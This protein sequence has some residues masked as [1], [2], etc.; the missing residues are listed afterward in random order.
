MTRIG[1][2]VSG[3]ATAEN[4]TE[5]WVIVIGL[6]VVSTTATAAIRVTS[7]T[8]WN[9]AASRGRTYFP[10]CQPKYWATLYPQDSPV[11]S[12]APKVAATNPRITTASASL[13]AA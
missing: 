12:A 11:S 8:R 7:T 10:H 5:Y 13:P 4:T 2:Y 3:S 6:I 1:K 9:R